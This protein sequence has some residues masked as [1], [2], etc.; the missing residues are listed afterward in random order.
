MHERTAYRGFA[1]DNRTY[2]YTST[3]VFFS[4]NDTDNEE[5]FVIIVGREIAVY[6]ILC[7]YPDS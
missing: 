2:T 6:C 4:R 5:Y 3:F 7:T 1:C